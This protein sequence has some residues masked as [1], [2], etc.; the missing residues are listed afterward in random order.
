MIPTSSES[1]VKRFIVIFSFRTFFGKL[2]KLNK[3]YI[4]Y[5]YVITFC[6]HCV[7]YEILTDRR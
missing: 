1:I 3:R 4:Y 7:E 5:N 6:S 2:R